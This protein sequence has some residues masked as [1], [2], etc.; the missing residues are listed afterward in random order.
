MD[1]TLEH[2]PGNMEHPYAYEKRIEIIVNLISKLKNELLRLDV[3]VSEVISRVRSE[4]TVS[5]TE[6]Y[7]TLDSNIEI[8]E[9]ERI[10]SM[11]PDIVKIIGKYKGIHP[12]YR[13][14]K[15]IRVKEWNPLQMAGVLWK[16][17]VNPNG[18][19]PWKSMTYLFK[20][21]V[22]ESGNSSFKYW[23]VVKNYYHRPWS[24]IKS[25]AS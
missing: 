22:C 12:M 9:F 10:D 1:F 23:D 8:L 19:V 16:L 15:I 24:C 2:S 17:N 11:F 6:L 21:P 13:D 14:D 3:H 5:K 25:A 7:E 4:L 18:K 20:C